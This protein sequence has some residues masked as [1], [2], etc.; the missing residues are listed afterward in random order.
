MGQVR[1]VAGKMRHKELLKLFVAFFV[2]HH[3]VAGEDPFGIGVDDKDGFLGGI[4]QDGIGGFWPSPVDG[5]Q[6]RAL[7]RLR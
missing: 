2:G 1:E 4:E 6:L 3:T 5:E 7:G